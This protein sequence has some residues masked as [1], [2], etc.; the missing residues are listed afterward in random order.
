MPNDDLSKIYSLLLALALGLIIGVER[1]WRERDYEGERRPAG[2]RTFGL[3]GLS[4]GI[5]SILGNM[6]PAL[7]ATGLGLTIAI[8]MIA[9]WRQ[10]QSS[11]FMG[12]TTI[13]AAFIA[14]SCG[15]LAAAGFPVPATAGAI[16]TAIILGAKER[17]H[18]FVFGLDQ[19]EIVAALQF[20]LIA[21]VVLPLAPNQRFGP[22]DALNPFEIWLMVV[23]VSGLSFLG[24]VSARVS[25][26]KSGIIGTAIL[27][28]FVSS[29]AVTLSFARM[30]KR[31]PQF[32]R[33]L[34]AGVILASAI[35][36]ARVAIIA[37]AVWPPLVI[38]L[39]APLS[40]MVLTSG[41]LGAL[42][43]R[44]QEQTM[45]EIHTFSNPLEFLPAL[46]FAGLL[47]AVTLASR[48]LEATFGAEGVYAVALASG[49][50]DVDA[51]TLSISRFAS[52]GLANHIAVFAILLATGANTLVK[53]AL[54]AISGNTNM[55]RMVSAVLTVTIVVGGIVTIIMH[56]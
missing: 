44:R 46:F 16:A 23:L 15:G 2:L 9:Y 43:L 30:A 8:M 3:I 29:T 11:V 19:K 50:A 40:A 42:L 45:T 26:A 28:G 6:F 55:R 21:G 20:L 7:P 34:T 18:R 24:Y 56:N 5:T 36:Y 25:R 17:L 14:Y 13:Y 1:E 38:K 31:N 41:F 52:D 27:G 47:A 53:L 48:W 49:L 51:I 37:G 4:G 35:M 39:G 33:T 10:S 22:Y 32:E 12:V 54:V